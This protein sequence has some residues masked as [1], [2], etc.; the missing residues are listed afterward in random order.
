MTNNK[1][2]SNKAFFYI[3]LEIKKNY[4][5]FLKIIFAFLILGLVLNANKPNEF[6][7]DFIPFLG[8]SVYFTNSNI[9]KSK[10]L[11]TYLANNTL[12]KK[13]QLAIRY[14]ENTHLWTG[15]SNR[16]FNIEEIENIF[17][18]AQKELIEK[19]FNLYDEI[20][21]KTN[22]E[23][24]R[25]FESYLATKSTKEKLNIENELSL[26]LTGNMIAENKAK[27]I[28]NKIKNKKHIKIL[29]NLIIFL[30]LGIITGVSIIIIREDYKKFIRDN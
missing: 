16:N 21:K 19:K 30:L 17:I 2:A 11:Q 22:N 13:N 8:E 9:L 28:Y 27:I 26:S 25:L 1:N 24:L 18:E 10:T 15:S 14:D 20:N 29:Q 6:E 4:V 7:I 3:V 12:N 5:F 23:F